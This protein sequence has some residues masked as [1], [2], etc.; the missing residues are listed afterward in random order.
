MG[1][2]TSAQVRLVGSCPYRHFVDPTTWRSPSTCHFRAFLRLPLG[3][4][5]TSDRRYCIF[6]DPACQIVALDGTRIQKGDASVKRNRG[7][8]LCVVLVLLLVTG[9]ASAGPSQHVPLLESAART[10]AISMWSSGW[11]DIAPG[12]LLTL[13]HNY[14]GN[15]DDYTV[16]V[17]CLD[18]DAGGLGVNHR[19]FGGMEANGHVFGVA[20]Q[21][22]T[23]TS[24]EILRL[25]DDVFA[26]KVLVRIWVP[27]T[28]LL[29]DSGWVDI[30][31]GQD[32]TL[33]HNAGG[34]PEEYT[35][36]M[37]FRNPAPGNV[38][39]NVRAAGGLDAGGQKLGA[40]WEKLTASSVHVVRFAD[41]TFAP[42]A[43]IM[44]FGPDPPSYDSGWRA[45]NPGNRLTLTH[46]LGGNVNGYIVRVSTRDTTPDGH[47]INTLHGGGDEA[48]GEFFGSNWELLSTSSIGLFRQADDGQAHSADE[49]RVWI[50]TTR[51]I[52]L[53]I[54]TRSVPL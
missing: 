15:P 41:D 35:V 44:I 24:I 6:R 8:L 7:D 43:R 48:G 49:M 40:A 50:W 42:Q 19:A 13:N 1:G 45:V 32:V 39:V 47:G 53:P 36:G 27:E 5:P 18:A 12:Q 9:V 38:G 34:N 10:S 22:L 54:V 16:D 4:L 33:T 14:G 17:W 21:R 52:Y 29:Y 2:D 20:W 25:P 51:R 23:A 30:E 31:P 26:D 11:T 3:L 37:R 28:P 46:N